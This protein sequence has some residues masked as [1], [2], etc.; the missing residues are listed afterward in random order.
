M[1]ATRSPATTTCS[2][3][4]SSDLLAVSIS[5]DDGGIQ[6]WTCT[7]CQATGWERDGA[8]IARDAALAH[9]PRR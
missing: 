2:T 5:M 8:Q 3:C 9:I 4:G 1:N 7:M 6:F